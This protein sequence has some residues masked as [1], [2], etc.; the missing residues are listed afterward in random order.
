MLY[1]IF[2][3]SAQFA[4]RWYYSELIVQG[5]E[6]IPANGPLLVVAN[7][8]NA[9]V[10]AMIV[11]TTLRRR[12]LITARATLF[13]GRTLAGLLRRIGVVPLLRVQDVAVV[14]GTPGLL[15]RNDASL[16]RVTDA[17]RLGEVV[18]IFPEGISHDR[19]SMAPLKSGAARI[20]LQAL[21]KGAHTLHILPIGLVYEEKE[22]P[23]TRVLVKIGRPMTVGA[24]L[25]N[26]PAR[27]A[28]ALT[29]EIAR[30]LHRVTLNFATEDRAVR[31][32][33]LARAF[34]LLRGGSLETARGRDLEDEVLTAAR[35][36]TATEA[37]E[38]SPPTLQVRADV[39]I[40]GLQGLETS[41]AQRG[42][43][44]PDAFVSSRVMHGLLFVL[45][46]MA[47]ACAFLPLAMLGR[48]SHWL[49]LR[50]ARRL[51]LYTLRSD[52]SRD[53]PAMRTI[54]IGL[55][56]VPAWYAI[57]AA[58]I[59]TLA[60]GARAAIW[61]SI[62]FLGA[63][64]DARYRGRIEGALQR[65]R[66]FLVYRTDRSFQCAVVATSRDLLQQAAEL[67]VA[68]LEIRVN[69]P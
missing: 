24:W 23:G 41:L 6:H 20:A 9:L 63:N 52:P 56:T 65:A 15:A 25:A 66:A 22:R 42:I 26:N 3:V 11:G 45:R 36:E 1:G 34:S 39:L 55:V 49:P 27:G 51:A 8:P 50:T 21:G 14:A 30:A 33:R 2:R 67:E 62:S 61:L 47:L 68:L 19:P 40:T 53:Q 16:E 35:I 64:V 38:Q 46:E 7:H 44:L 13:E 29:Q 10:D 60:G 17:L 57:Q 5:R 48:V 54:L 59:S 37:L 18:L 43:A 12:V 31:S 69:A 32:I 58:V 4:L 28:T